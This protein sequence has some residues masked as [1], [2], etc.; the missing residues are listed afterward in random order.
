MMR[1][2]WSTDQ[3]M[4]AAT[5]GARA[6]VRPAATRTGMIE[7]FQQYPAMPIAVVARCPDHARDPRSVAEVVLGIGVVADDV[8]A[9]D[10]LCQV[11]ERRQSGVD[12]GDHNGRVAGGQLPQIR[13]AGQPWSPFEAPDRI[14]R[15]GHVAGACR[16]RPERRQS[17]EQAQE[18]HRK[19]APHVRQCTGASRASIDQR[20]ALGRSVRPA[21]VPAASPRGAGT[22][23]NR[24]LGRVFPWKPYP[25]ATLFPGAGKFIKVGG[26]PR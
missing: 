4:P 22:A 9:G 24:L 14:V 16:C 6:P 7:H 10:H 25:F 5:A 1:A 23:S 8:P 2:P 18:D 11:G 21:P 12:D 20:S 15:L 26:C 3:R 19:D 17:P 13:R